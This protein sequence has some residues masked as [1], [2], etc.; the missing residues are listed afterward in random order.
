MSGPMHQPRRAWTPGGYALRTLQHLAAAGAQAVPD[1]ELLAACNAERIGSGRRRRMPQYRRDIIANLE[2]RGYIEPGPAPRTWRLLPAARAELE[3]AAAGLGARASLLADADDAPEPSAA[4]PMAAHLPGERPTLADLVR[5]DLREAI[6][7][8]IVRPPMSAADR[9]PCT[10]RAGADEALRCPS[11]R[12]SRLY[13]RDGRVTT[14]D[15]APV[16]AP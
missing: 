12:G 6:T 2:A 9:A 11:R 3:R 16:S 1:V 13:W 15:G 14:L 4:V 7:R 8:S 5:P 10:E